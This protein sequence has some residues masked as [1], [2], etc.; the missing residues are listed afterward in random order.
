LNAPAGST[1]SVVAPASDASHLLDGICFEAAHALSGHAFVLNDQAQ[2]DGLYDQIDRSGLCR[3]RIPRL[4][5]DFAGRAVVGTWTYA[6]H[7]CTA[8]HE[9]VQIWRDDVTRTMTMRYRFAVE[10]ECPYELVRPLWVAVEN[11]DAYAI[12]L[13]ITG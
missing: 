8:R 1:S 3:R 9:Q 11:P 4:Q 5:F 10:G 6:P 2:L 12:R 13:E 7:G